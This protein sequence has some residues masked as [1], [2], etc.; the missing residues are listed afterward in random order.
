M[1]LVRRRLHST[2]PWGESVLACLVA[3]ALVPMFAVSTASASMQ[4]EH[5]LTWSG[6]DF[7]VESGRDGDLV[8][9]QG[10]YDWEREGRPVLPR[11]GYSFVVP[12]G[13][14]AE[15]LEIV[16]AR[17]VDM[18][19]VRLVVGSDPVDSG[20]D[21]IP[22]DG[23]VDGTLARGAFDPVVPTVL[24]A[25]HPLRG[26]SIAS[27]D[28]VPVRV[29][30]EGHV[31]RLAELRV[32]LELNVDVR[33]ND[34]ALRRVAWPGQANRDAQLVS[35]MVEND[36]DVEA[37]APPSGVDPSNARFDFEVE[38]VVGLGRVARIV[39][40]PVDM[41]ILTD[42]TLA[43][44]FQ[45]LADY[46]T[47]RGVR[48]VV[49]TVSQILAVARPGG[50]VQETLRNYVRTCY[51]QW[52]V[53][54]LLLGGDAEIL[55]PRYARSGFYPAAG[56]TD[57]PSD[58]YF[59]ALDGNWNIDG[60]GL[61][62]EPYRSFLETGDEA[63]LLAEIAIGRVPLKSTEQVDG[64]VDKVFAYE[65]PSS[66]AYA[67]RAIFMSE[68]LFP[69]AWQEGDTITLDGAS[70]S[71][72]IVFDSIIGGGNLMQSWR[73]YENFTPYPGAIPETKEAALDSMSTGN[74]ALINHIGHG[75]YYNMSMGINDGNIFVADVDQSVNNPSDRPFVL[76]A[77][78]CSSG[79]FDF[80]CLLERFLQLPDRGGVATIGATRAAFPSTANAY[81]QA[82]YREI[83]VNG[84]TR[85]GDAQL[86]SR[87]SQNATTAV[88]GS[89][90]WT[91]FGYH[92]FGDP[93]MHLWREEPQLPTVSAPSVVVAGDD[94]LTVSVS[95]GG[96]FEGATVALTRTDGGFAA[97]TTNAS[98][99]VTLP[100]GDLSD[101]TGSIEL[102]VSSANTLPVTQTITVQ[103]ASAAHVRSTAIDAVD[104]DGDG[105]GQIEAGETIAWAFSFE[106]DGGAPANGVTAELIP[107]S[108]PGVSL[109]TSSR[110]ILSLIAGQTVVP[111]PFEF[112][113]AS[114]AVDGTLAQFEMQV[115]AGSEVWTQPVSF[116]I[117][118]PE[119]DLARIRWDDSADGNGN[120]VIE[121][122][123]T[124]DLIVEVSNYGGAAV[125][126]LSASLSDLSGGG[127]TIV[128]GS[129]AAAAPIGTREVGLVTGL[130]IAEADASV[131]NLMQLELTDDEGRV[132]NKTIDLRPPAAPN[133]PILDTTFGPDKIVVRTDEI[134][135]PD[136][137]GYRVYR[138][139]G[140]EGSFD[141][142]TDDTILGTGFIEDAGLAALTRYGY[143]ITYV[144]E[145]G[146][147]SA[148][149]PV[150]SAST[151]PPELAGGF[152]LP[153][154]RELAGA[155][156]VGNMIPGGPLVATFGADFL[157]AIDANGQE[158][159]NGDEDAQTRGPLAGV[160]SPDAQKRFTPS[161]VV[162]ADLDDD[163]IDELIG[164][165][166]INF[167]VWVVR[168]D[169]TNF[170]GWPQTM[171]GKAWATPTAADLDNDGDLE[172]IVNNTNRTTY[173][174]HHDGTDFHDG[175]GIPSTI[176][177]FQ[178]RDAEIF[179]RSSVA[180]FDVDGDGTKEV[181]VPSSRRDGNDNFLHALRNDG[182]NAPGWP[183]NL[184]PLGW[185]VSHPTVADVDR[186]GTEEIFLV[187]EDDKLHAWSP[188]GSYLTGY[189][190]FLESRAGIRDSKHPA[191]AFGDFDQDNQLEL[192]TVAILGASDCDVY[193]QE[194][195]GTVL[196][197]WPVRLPGLSESS[198][199]VGDI[200]GDFQLD[201]V[202]GIG[203]GTDNTPNQLYALNA[204]GTDVAGFPITLQGAVRA[205]PVITD[206][207]ED[208]DVDIVYAGFDLLLHVWD[209]PFA[210]NRQLVPWPTFQA[211]N[212]RTGVYTAK[213]STSAPSVSLSARPGVEGVVLEARILGATQGLEFVLERREATDA[214]FE[215]I[216]SGVGLDGSLLRFVDRSA[217]AGTSYV[218]RLTDEEGSF[219][220]ESRA[221][222]VPNLRLALKQA[223]PNPFNP[224][225]TL[226]FEIPGNAGGKVPSVLEIFDVTGRRV[227]TLVSEPLAPGEHR[228]RWNGLDDGG[229]SVASG[230]YFARVRAAGQ[231]QSMKLTLVK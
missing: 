128:N 72:S 206:F 223:V 222:A 6:D 189:P 145:S 50:D 38:P 4:V 114:D 107:V 202:F 203:G 93:A 12:H 213:V 54:Y 25:S 9:L 84:N 143:E 109:I 214:R 134:L 198:P 119:I 124:V 152:P 231:A 36:F 69:Q 162:M 208:G 59:A 60:D 204:D 99:D 197:G 90:R 161:G 157:Y 26:W 164:T 57:I 100:L 112:S 66:P 125:N 87:S 34:L 144:D 140:T 78:N 163:G 182:T 190:K 220:F 228:V 230:T 110:S 3:V 129:G 32:R 92:L 19:D 158:L 155:V 64:W 181:L 221:V 30:A 70:Y 188:D 104:L 37:F 24:G 172:I 224:S 196:P 44:S 48:T 166:W 83:F 23:F 205:V 184:G 89:H 33:S 40:E 194:L 56:F 68:V 149:S 1:P 106:N 74:F 174:W 97:G 91:H 139:E 108:A 178:R 20:G 76:H 171:N 156:A 35:R 122:G 58:L 115:S 148:P 154:Q 191:V 219:A 217:R 117:G 212:A 10:A 15:G 77:L 17:W 147:E 81:Q 177:I 133:A 103:S 88:E 82:F 209:M 73:M 173:V 102:R 183:A 49:V 130:R 153:V 180:V 169:G 5:R 187:T 138:R 170:P 14:R 105:D 79:A 61:Y 51:E 63:D 132:F 46:R 226:V 146:V 31:Q 142:V 27:I 118:A 55:A 53:S 42:D 28:V 80:D 52:G 121:S 135:D 86:V 210:Y 11:A 141:E 98:G 123:E 94:E 21:P 13:M 95:R 137:R 200:N 131:E 22:A 127:V 176:G 126:T 165:N 65:N 207:D 111:D 116:V 7:V 45:R 193:I 218:Y 216:A 71:E 18:P 85:I 160:L 62:S 195:D 192:V 2:F 159:V 8:R 47:A 199:V 175:D 151:A 75:F 16:D 41:L 39:P 185:C 29:D 43:P 113:I 101:R 136:V 179:S 67:G 150:V 120:G 201:V 96:P 186:D 167:Q 225:T 229:N 215:R 227:K 211:D 168:A